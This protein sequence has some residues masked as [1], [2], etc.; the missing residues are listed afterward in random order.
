MSTPLVSVQLSS[1]SQKALPISIRLQYLERISRRAASGT[2]A[3][4]YRYTS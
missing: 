3:V 1:V 2:G 4:T